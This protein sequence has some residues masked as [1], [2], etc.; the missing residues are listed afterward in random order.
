MRLTPDGPRG[1]THLIVIV[2]LFTKHTYLFPTVGCTATNLALAVWTYWCNFGLTDAI[3]SDQGPDLTSQL[4]RE[5]TKLAGVRHQFSIANCHANGVERILKEVSRH[6]RALVYDKRLTNAFEDPTL[7]PSVQY[8]LNSHRSAETNFTPFELMFGNDAEKYAMIFKQD[9][10]QNPTHLWLSRLNDNLKLVRQLSKEYQQGLI[11][12]RQDKDTP[13]TLN[14]YQRGDF[15]TFNSGPKVLPKMSC[16][17]K[18]PYIVERQSKNDVLC[19]DLVTDAVHTF[20]LKDLEPFFCQSKDDAYAAALRDKHQ[21][22]V[23]RVVSY[24]GNCTKRTQMFF[25]LEFE[26]GDIKE[27]PWT[28]DIQCEA[29]YSFCR[30]FNYLY[31]LTLDVEMAKKHRL[32]LNRE[33]ISA[34][35]PGDLAY[36]DLRFFGDDWYENLNL[37]DW[38]TTSYVLEFEYTHWYHKSSHKK[39]SGKVLLTGETYALDNYLVFAWGSILKFDPNSMVLVTKSLISQYPDIG[40]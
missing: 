36:V 37:P 39:I 23:K 29:Y 35:K 7:L 30:R 31:H 40:N 13:E 34:V 22:V 3:I 15:V 2:N 26:D 38:A 16:R 9:N 25:T 20:S 4:F 33:S 8:I 10:G 24:R 12:H 18:G 6:L 21:F 11:E 14:T 28:P 17:Y 19:R 1:E 5:L 27:L 32:N